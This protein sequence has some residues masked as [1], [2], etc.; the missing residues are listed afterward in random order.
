VLQTTTSQQDKKPSIDE[1]QSLILHKLTQ[2]ESTHATPP[3]SQ[4]TPTST[5]SASKPTDKPGEGN[6][7]VAKVEGIY[8]NPD[9]DNKQKVEEL[10][11]LYLEEVLEELKNT[12]RQQLQLR[13][14]EELLVYKANTVFDEQ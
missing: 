7:L 5:P 6:E 3:T 10:Y 12:H 13:L 1:L 2:L 4:P 8:G 11:K 9:M 14:Q